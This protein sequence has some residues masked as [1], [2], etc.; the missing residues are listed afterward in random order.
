MT[1]SQMRL[2]KIIS[3]V[4][5]M[6]LCILVN[7]MMA[8]GHARYLDLWTRNEAITDWMKRFYKMDRAR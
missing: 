8:K 5:Q 2:D 3:W 7:K 4:K 1:K 6:G